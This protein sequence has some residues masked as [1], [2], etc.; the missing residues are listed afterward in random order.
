MTVLMFGKNIRSLKEKISIARKC[1]LEETVV[2]V[3]PSMR[4]SEKL[5]GLQSEG[6]L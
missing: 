2:Y 5:P 4:V 3:D 6:T 1:L